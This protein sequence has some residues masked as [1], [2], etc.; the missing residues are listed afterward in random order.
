[1][2]NKVTE[3]LKIE[4]MLKW[5]SRNA[6]IPLEHV[7]IISKTILSM[8][9]REQNIIIMRMCDNKTLEEVGKAFGVTRERIRQIENK[10]HMKIRCELSTVT[11]NEVHI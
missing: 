11:N 9:P 4:G 2:E 10:L 8:T 3:M 5:L 7:K 6:E 1:M